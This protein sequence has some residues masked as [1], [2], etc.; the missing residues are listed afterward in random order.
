IASNEVFADAYGKEL[1]SEYAEYTEELYPDEPY[2]YLKDSVE[3][4]LNRD[5]SYEFNKWSRY[6]VLKER[7]KDLLGEQTIYYNSAFEKIKKIEAKTILP[8]GTVEKAKQI[9]DFSTYAGLPVYSSSRVKVIT[10]PSVVEDSII[11]VKSTVK[12][13]KIF[14]GHFWEA[15]G[16]QNYVH[17]ALSDFKITFPSEMKLF[18]EEFKIDSKP[19]ITES[20][21]GKYTTYYWSKEDMPAIEPEDYRPSIS[22]IAPQVNI[23]TIR[24]WEDL[25]SLINGLFKGK[26]SYNGKMKKIVHKLIEDK[27]T[28]I[29]KLEAILKYMQDNFRYVSISFGAGSMEPHKATETFSNKYGDCKDQSVL[30][31]SL[32]SI[33]GIE[34]TYAV[35]HYDDY[36]PLYEAPFP[37]IFH[38]VIL[39]VHL[40]DQSLYVDPLIANLAP[41]DMYVSLDS[42]NML[43][44]DD[45]RAWFERTKGPHPSDYNRNANI[46]IVL[47][48]DGSAEG[49]IETIYSR[50]VSVVMRKTF[51]GITEK[52]KKELFEIFIATLGSG[53]EVTNFTFADPNDYR[54][55][56]SF[57]IE[58]KLPDFATIAGNLM[59]INQRGVNSNKTL[60][61][62]EERLYPILS[63]Y[64][65]VDEGTAE[66]TLPENYAIEYLPESFSSECGLSEVKVSYKNEGNKILITHSSVINKIELPKT[67]YEK[68]RS[69]F[70][71]LRK[72][73]KERL[74]FKK[75]STPK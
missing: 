49:S 43:L 57:K 4:N 15:W 67:S 35:V 69:M 74:I 16:F 72:K 75:Q 59:I 66:Y 6:K 11:D 18:I 33:A 12:G 20:K 10:M 71:E 53:G 40:K 73:T 45:E 70:N 58:F 37:S 42:T 60:F 22:F 68:V 38:H 31:S 30:L 17:V 52:E 47:E 9:Q 64:I 14:K 36:S 50:A 8:D 61:A 23:S 62:K 32:L 56:F 26:N 55:N 39:K 41:E 65:S 2:I 46:K 13:R 3:I 1:Q 7:A 25:G 21:D 5:G 19:E 28:D 54:K 44:F 24:S 34:S 63:H 27:E 51:K 29:A 48:D